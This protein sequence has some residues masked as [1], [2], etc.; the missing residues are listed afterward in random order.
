[1][2]VR[3]SHFTRDPNLESSAKSQSPKNHQITFLLSLSK[4]LPYESSLYWL[5]KDGHGYNWANSNDL[6]PKVTTDVSLVRGILPKMAETFRF[7]RIYNKSPT[8]NVH[9]IHD[10]LRFPFVQEEEEAVDVEDDESDE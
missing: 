8:Y 7:F 3:T 5:F 10:I 9:S 1:M 2:W 4:G 6:T